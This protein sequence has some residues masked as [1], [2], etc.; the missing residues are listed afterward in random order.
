MPKK[1]SKAQANTIRTRLEDAIVQYNDN[2]TTIEKL[3]SIVDK[4]DDLSI[5]A[6]NGTVSIVPEF[7]QWQDLV[8]LNIT[9]R[10]QINDME[11]IIQSGAV[12][13]EEEANPFA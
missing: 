13:D 5:R 7:K 3:K 11:Q 9:L 8:K 6:S 12:K 2:Q 10:K 4:Y 1:N